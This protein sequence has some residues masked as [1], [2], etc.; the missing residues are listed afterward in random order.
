MT[1]Y[2]SLR[3]IRTLG[4]WSSIATLALLAGCASTPYIPVGEILAG[5]PE[6]ASLAKGIK[7][8]ESQDA[9]ALAPDGYAAAVGKFDEAITAARSGKGA[10]TTGLAA[11]GLNALNKV[12]ADSETSRDLLREALAART[13]AVEAGANQILPEKSREMEAK[14]RETTRLVEKGNIEAAKKR[15][16]EL[17]D[18]YSK[19]ELAGLKEGAVAAARATIK[20]AKADGADK[21]AP[22][23]FK[24]AKE[25]MDLVT[26]ILDA[27]REDTERANLHA[28]RARDLAE[29]SVAVAEIIRDFDRRDFSREDAVLW[30]QQQLAEIYEPVGTELPFDEPNRAV[31]LAMQQRYADLITEG[32]AVAAAG[33]REAR[34]LEDKLT[35]TKKELAARDE[36]EAQRRTR[37]NA[38]QSLFVAGEANVYRKKENVLISAYGFHFKTGD[39]EIES[40][41]FALCNKIIKAIELFPRS[42]IQI[43]G[44]TDSTGSAAINKTVSE[45]RAANVSK[46][47]NEVGN[48]PR[49]RLSS[50]G[51]GKE[52]PV[53]SNETAEGRAEN[54]RVEILI[55]NP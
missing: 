20:R 11:A 32:K 34:Q 47:L 33:E 14:L 6:L 21:L 52:R 10:E 44:H 35:V 46:F 22:K 37:F 48:I 36:I 26:S 49:S 25:E 24:L 1:P 42:L 51:E 7:T 3:S 50:S 23:T 8:A 43:S 41:N 55:K 12:R 27:N 4:V 53:A 9:K 17:I 28:K 19:L 2:R 16:Q 31:I 13:R 5:N 54:R 38:V 30:Y 15:I 18:G 29:R 39:S 45:A 40:N